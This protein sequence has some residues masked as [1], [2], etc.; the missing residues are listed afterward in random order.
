MK[1][2]FPSIAQKLS[3]ESCDR[4]QASKNSFEHYQHVMLSLWV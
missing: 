4:L 1:I 3:V 2:E